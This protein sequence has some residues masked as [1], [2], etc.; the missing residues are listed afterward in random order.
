MAWGFLYITAISEKKDGIGMARRRQAL[1]L[2]IRLLVTKIGGYQ[3]CCTALA[4]KRKDVGM[5]YL[6]GLDICS[7]CILLSKLHLWSRDKTKRLE[8]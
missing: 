5:S 7:K 2:V 1:L 6:D 3:S 4:L 8:A